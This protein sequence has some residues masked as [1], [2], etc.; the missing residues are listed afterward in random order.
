MNI[1]YRLLIDLE[2]L[3]ARE[4]TSNSKARRELVPKGGN[5]TLGP[6]VG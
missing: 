6:P 4:G 1:Y 2:M 3:W 5:G